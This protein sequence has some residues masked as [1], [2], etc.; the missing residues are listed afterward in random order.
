MIKIL[1]NID[2]L[3]EVLTSKLLVICVLVMLLLSVASIVLRWGGLSF[4]WLDPVVRHLVFLCTFLG[5]A[6]ATGR[7]THIGIDIIG[8]QLEARKLNHYQDLI[9]R[10]IY[11]ASF[12]VLIW[13]IKASI[14]FTKVEF[15]YGRAEFLGIHSG[16]LVS[17][18]PVGFAVICYRYFYLFINSFNKLEKI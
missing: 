8:K 14:E 17:I 9:N 15:E 11:L 1:G 5:G 6:I 13:M 10:A 16:F 18:I 4:L 3:I 2:H 12:A 7:G